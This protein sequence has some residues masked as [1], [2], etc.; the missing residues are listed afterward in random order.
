[1]GKRISVLGQ[2]T[3]FIPVAVNS[4]WLAGPEYAA[5]DIFAATGMPIIGENVSLNLEIYF[6]IWEGPGDDDDFGCLKVTTG[7]TPSWT[8]MDGAACS[9]SS[10][11]YY[12]ETAHII[13][14][15]LLAEV[16]P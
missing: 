16:P 6:H 12:N 2:P 14:I 7:G 13:G 10:F 1:M 3:Y 9:L 5:L 11:P 15:S 8:D 4:K